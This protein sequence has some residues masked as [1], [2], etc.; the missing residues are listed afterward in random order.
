MPMKKPYAESCDQNRGPIL[1]VLGRELT[2]TG[3]VLEIGSGT[4]QHAVHFGAALTSLRWQPTERAEHL[5]GI[6]LWLAEADLPNLLEPL[7]LDVAMDPWPVARADHVFS[8]NTTHIMHW[9]QVEHLFAG[10]GR[11]LVPGGR[12]CLYGPFNYDGHFTTDSNARFDAWLKERDP[13]S[14]LRDVADL[15]RLARSAGL[16]LKR[17]HPMPSNNRTL[18]WERAGDDRVD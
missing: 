15:D 14:G 17:D 9:P 6:R 13:L 7:E 11:V 4:G 18:V 12:F 10:V 16:V 2:G 3:L 1:E 8:A 5:P